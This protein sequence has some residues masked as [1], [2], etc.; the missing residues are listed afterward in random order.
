[1]EVGGGMEVEGRGGGGMEDRGRDGG[2]E[3][4][5]VGGGM[6]VE[7]RGGGGMDDRG[8]DGGERERGMEV[9][10]EE[11]RWRWE[12]KREHESFPQYSATYMCSGGSC[13]PGMHNSTL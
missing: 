4:M 7:G 5:E 10:V 11:E 13:A 12:E 8:R 2:E 1:M 3:G 6:E 9:G